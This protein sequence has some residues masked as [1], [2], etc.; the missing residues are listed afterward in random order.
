MTHDAFEAHNRKTPSDFRNHAFHHRTPFCHCGGDLTQGHGGPQFWNCRFFE[1]KGSFVVE[2][3]LF[4]AVIAS[5]ACFSSPFR[6]LFF[7]ARQT[8]VKLYM[9]QEKVEEDR[10]IREQEKMFFAKKKAEMAD[11]LHGEEEKL[12]KETIA[13]AMA[14]AELVLKKAGATNISHEGLE[15]IAKWKLGMS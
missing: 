9:K 14:E 15:A 12:Y 11:K 4:V 10:Y 7:F 5:E 6:F 2:T 8:P 3:L 1:G 13:P